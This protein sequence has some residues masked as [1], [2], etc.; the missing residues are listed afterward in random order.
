MD[1]RAASIELTKYAKYRD[2]ENTH[3]DKIKIKVINDPTAMV[4][5]IRSGRVQY[6]VGVAALDAAA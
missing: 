3:L 1:A 5:A 2:A 6:G 4:S